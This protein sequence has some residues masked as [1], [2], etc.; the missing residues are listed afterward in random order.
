MNQDIK[1]QLKQ[2]A[3]AIQAQAAARLDHKDF[4]Q[5]LEAMLIKPD[6]R[7]QRPWLVAVAAAVCLTVLTWLTWQDT[8]LAEVENP[9]DLVVLDTM[10]LNLNQYPQTV[11][12]KL[13]QPL[14]KEQQAIIDDLKALRKQLLSI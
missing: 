7:Q 14:V 9:V 1:H 13:N 4:S 12:Q 6:K 8:E 2:D 11:A 3:R 5:Q 10:E